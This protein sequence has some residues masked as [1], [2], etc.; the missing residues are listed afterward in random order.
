MH[1]AEPSGLVGAARAGDRIDRLVE[2]RFLDVL[3]RG[4]VL[5]LSGAGMSTDSGI[6]DYR[7]SKARPHVPVTFAEFVGSAD[8]RRRYWSRSFRG[9]P[10]V[11]QAAPNPGHTAVTAMQQAGILSG[12]IT[13][14]VDGLHTSAGTRD[15]LELHGSL[16]AVRC[17]ECG[18]RLRRDGIQ[19]VLADLN[20]DVVAMSP[21]AALRPD[22]DADLPPAGGG[23]PAAEPFRV[24]PCPQCGGRLKPDVVF[25]GEQVPVERVSTGLAM[26]DEAAAVL[27]LG[28]SLA[29]HS[30][31]RY[32]VRGAKQGKPILIVNRGPTRGDTFATARV[33]GGISAVLPDLAART[34]AR[35]IGTSR[36]RT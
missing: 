31:R 8:A 23:T 17:L 12:V 25:F 29:V 7:G 6:P 21:S 5:V 11:S 30:G 36:A 26:V 16:S 3:S 2:S 4:G 32:A 15:V 34:T 27:V 24:P 19:R 13:Q 33:D 20:P 22:G 9:W 1:K 14:N 35:P 10:V 18:T 28:S